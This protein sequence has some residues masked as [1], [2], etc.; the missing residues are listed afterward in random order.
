VR[1]KKLLQQARLGTQ[2]VVKM[3]QPS[4]DTPLASRMVE[5]EGKEMLSLFKTFEVE[6]GAKLRWYADDQGEV[7]TKPGW[8]DEPR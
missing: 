8:V 1:K 3:Q 6:F 5:A 2:S 4:V 7:G